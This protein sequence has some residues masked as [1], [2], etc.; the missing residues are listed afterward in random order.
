MQKVLENNFVRLFS[1][2]KNSKAFFIS[3]FLISFFIFDLTKAESNNSNFKKIVPPKLDYLESKKELEDYILDTDDI[4]YIEFF[5][6]VEFTNTYKVS[7]EGEILLPRLYET[8][9]R[10]L[11]TSELQKLLEKRYLEF[12]IEPELKVS[13]AEFKSL[14]VLVRGEVRYPGFY[15]FP[16]YKSSFFLD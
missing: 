15:K 6:A 10:G 1:F 11:T 3:C 8:Y 16:S 13:I 5:P 12:L 14:R 7:T 9:V 2:K 4:L